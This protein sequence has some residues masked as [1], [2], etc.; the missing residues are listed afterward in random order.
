LIGWFVSAIADVK[1]R[2]P[3]HR[4]PEISTREELEAK[5]FYSLHYASNSKMLL[6]IVAMEE[7]ILLCSGK[8]ASSVLGVEYGQNL[9]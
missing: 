1:A 2:I 8:V 9:V 5:K 3:T 7:I 4:L 6:Y